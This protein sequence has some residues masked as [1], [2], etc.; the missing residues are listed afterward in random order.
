VAPPV[1]DTALTSVA[2]GLRTLK[3]LRTRA[4]IQDSALELFAEQGFDETTVEQIAARAEVSTATFFRYFGTKG[5]VIISGLGYPLPELEQAIIGRPSSENDLT[6]VRRAI[7]DV[8][9]P[10]LDQRRI[11]RQVRA[12]ATSPLLR[13][14]LTDLSVNWQ[15]VIA[16]ALAKRSGLK[17]PDKKCRLI[18]AMALAV[19]STVTNAW[20][21]D[22]VPQ[23]LGVAMDDGFELLGDLCQEWCPASHQRKATPRK[24]AHR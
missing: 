8:W 15:R 6:A 19:E 9:S 17:E 16:E 22:D 5:E 20:I 23:D 1:E 10:L 11:E 18:A 13:G 3:K 12:A 7:A 24:R 21:K 4:A 14:L 2:P